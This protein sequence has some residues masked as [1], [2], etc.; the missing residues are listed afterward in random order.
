MSE[1]VCAALEILVGDTSFDNGQQFC[2]KLRPG[3]VGGK[4]GYCSESRLNF[5]GE[6]KGR[7]AGNTPGGEACSRA[8]VRLLWTVV[9]CFVRVRSFVCKS[10][11]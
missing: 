7:E 4:V 10:D 11:V 3:G 6:G 8:C 2:Q 9:F 1:E 5:W